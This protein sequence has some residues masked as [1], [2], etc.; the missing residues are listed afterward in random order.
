[1]AIATF[2]A[3]KQMTMNED[4]YTKIPITNGNGEPD[5]EGCAAIV[6]SLAIIALF[7][8]VVGGIWL[9]AR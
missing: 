9:F 7:W 2:A 3:Q 6:A 4:D 8:I 5:R 1:M